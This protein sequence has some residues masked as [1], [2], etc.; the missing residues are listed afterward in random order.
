MT[1]R[2]VLI[3]LDGGTFGTLDALIEEG[4]MPFLKGFL[5]SGTRAQLLSVIPP[6]TPPGWTSLVTGRT[7]GN[8][9]GYGFFPL[10]VAR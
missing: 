6:L 2:V 7:P 9:G 5:A 10:R 1:N 3:G 4:V 8:H